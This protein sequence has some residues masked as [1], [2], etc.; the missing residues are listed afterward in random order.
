MADDIRVLYVDDEPV[1]LGLAKIFLEKSG[2]FQ[3]WTSLSAEEAL[4]TQLSSSYDAIVSDYQMPGM[5]GIAFLKCVRE[6]FGDIPFILFTGRGREEVVI[7]AINNGADFYLQKGGD[8]KAQF[9]ELSHKI[10]QAVAGQRAQVELRNA[11]DQIIASREELVRSE[12]QA[13]ENENK[14]RDLADRLPQMVF[15]TDMDLRITYVN[16][17]TIA[18][19]GFSPEIMGSGISVLT[20]IHPSQHGTFMESV[21]N[22]MNGIPFE[23]KEYIAFNKDK[24]PFPVT[25]YSSPIFRNKQLIGFRGVAVDISER[26]RAEEALFNSRQM[27]QSVL[28]TIPQRVFWKD[29]N[30]VF[31]GCNK[32]LAHDVG[33]SDSSEMIGKTD[34]DHS[35]SAIAEHFRADDREV[36]ETGKPKI[37]YEEP[38]IRPD[39]SISWLRT[40]KVPLRNR[41]GE[42]I[43]ILGTYEDITESKKAQAALFDSEARFRDLADRLPQMVFETDR[44]LRITYANCHAVS[45]FNLTEDE[46]GNGIPVLSLIDPAQHAAFMTSVQNLINNIHFEPKEYTCLKRDGSTFPVIIY[47]TL[48]YKN[49]EI[50]GFRGVVVD[51]SGW[52]KLEDGIRESEGKFRSLVENASDIVFSLDTKGNF[53]YVSPQW[54]ELLGHDPAEIIG[55]P[56]TALIHPSDLPRNIEVFRQAMTTGKKIHGLVYRIQHK[57]WTWR[58]HSQSAAPARNGSGAIV[59]YQGIC[60]DITERKRAEE[61][62]Q[63]V[64]KKLSLLSGITRHDINNQLMKLGGYVELLHDKIP[65]PSYDRDFS[66]IEAASRQIASLIQ[67]TEEYEE[68]GVHAPSWQNVRALASAVCRDAISGQVTCRNDVP[69]GLEIFADPLIAKVFFNLI[70]NA[71]RHGNSITD[72]R[73]SCREQNGNRIIVCEDDGNGVAAEEKEKIFDLGFGKNTGFGLAISREILDITGISITENG[74]PG[75]GAR[76]EIVVPNGLWQISGTGT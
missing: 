3:I 14:F 55:T 32:H 69:A 10:R 8:P 18:M 36:M 76:F 50:A 41:E 65:D 46:L 54:T 62:L 25:V 17:H 59:A 13:R 11:Y 19:Y 15:E 37:N 57:D 71:L 22:L 61:T 12:Q 20:F 48:I 33:Y 68:I 40:S 7:E 73:F 45:V 38:Q 43:G 56:A 74:T 44:D 24:K 42:I 67:F 63:Q 53:T 64:N 70:D 58:W 1:L 29:R 6:R 75:N 49:K 23:P 27:L 9:A 52:K 66:R 35:S 5:D 51:V 72:L 39:G 31:L 30:L 2:G 21:H 28:D 34:Y 4:G 60:H 26:K 16:Q 47:S